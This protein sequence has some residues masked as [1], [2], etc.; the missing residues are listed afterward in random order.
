MI[1]RGCSS[2]FVQRS[3]G[4]LLVC[5][6]IRHC[7]PQTHTPNN[8]S[9]PRLHVP[10]QRYHG[11]PTGDMDSVPADGGITTIPLVPSE[12]RTHRGQS[13]SGLYL[14]RFDKVD[15]RPL[16]F[17][18]GNPLVHAL[19]RN[20]ISPPSCPLPQA[21]MTKAICHAPKLLGSFS[22]ANGALPL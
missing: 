20:S 17:V 13:F 18:A 7:Q 14:H 1:L 16:P 15:R 5:V 6:I 10:F 12:N 11:S 22:R 8:C 4:Y 3:T 21:A 19:R 2:G 9:R